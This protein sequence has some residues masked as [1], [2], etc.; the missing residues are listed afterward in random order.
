M[1][2]DFLSRF[3][4]IAR[5]GADALSA[6]HDPALVCADFSDMAFHGVAPALPVWANPDTLG[7]YFSGTSGDDTQI[8]TVGND[9]FDYSQGGNDTLY[10][11]DGADK[12]IFG[13]FDAND[14]VDGGT[15][16]DH[17][18]PEGRLHGG[19]NVGRPR[20]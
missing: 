17:A 13:A 14:R 18:G 20:H 9:A 11:G 12:F 7:E 5:A 19:S 1:T 6:A 4:M 10:G 3:Q 8:G 15:S 2:S 16:S